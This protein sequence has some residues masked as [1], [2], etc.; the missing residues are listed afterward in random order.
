MS[1][2]GSE[3]ILEAYASEGKIS[4]L[5]KKC[6]RGVGRQVAFEKSSGAYV[7][8]NLDMDDSFRPVLQRLVDIY[9]AIS[10]GKVLAVVSDPN[11]WSQ[12][13]T[14]GSRGDISSIGGWRDLQY[15]EDWDLWSRAAAAGKYAWTVYPV[16]DRIMT[17]RERSS[18]LG[19]LRYRYG[20]YRDEMRLGRDVFRE[21]EK[22]TPLQRGAKLL[23][24]LSLPFQRSYRTAFNKTF[25]SSDSKYRIS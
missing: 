19:K 23:A 6:T 14:I 16:A 1:N 17:R 13:I 25:I 10:E 12:N 15:A 8:S 11:D 9:H 7:I 22:T 21:G 18:F 2:D 3:K 20:R 24:A 4:L 5:T